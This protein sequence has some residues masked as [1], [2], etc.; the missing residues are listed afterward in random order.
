M[1]VYGSI[2]WLARDIIQPMASGV[3]ILG[4]NAGKRTST[5]AAS[6]N[7]SGREW[8]STFDMERSVYPFSAWAIKFLPE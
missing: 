2:L 3:H 1:P 5:I 4:H 8:I 7:N 6:R